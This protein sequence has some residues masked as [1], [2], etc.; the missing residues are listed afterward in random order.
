MHHG[1]VPP[2]PAHVADMMTQVLV[3]PG[4]LPK[5]Y[6]D[7][8]AAFYDISKKI[9]HREVAWISGEEYDNYRKRAEIYVKGVEAVLGKNVQRKG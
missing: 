7:D 9:L 1:H 2:T 6:A 5:K 3:K 4:I 8:M